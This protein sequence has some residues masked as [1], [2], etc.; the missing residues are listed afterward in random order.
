VSTVGHTP[1]SEISS[2][3]ATIRACLGKIVASPAFKAS[4][5]PKQFLTFVVEKT[6]EGCPQ[7]IKER[8][9]GTEVFGRTADFE[10]SGDSIVRVNANEVRRRLAQYYRD[11]P[12]DD[13]VQIRLPQGSYVPEFVFPSE[14]PLPS[15]ALVAPPKG[16]R[17]R[18]WVAGGVL[19]LVVAGAIVGWRS[20]PSGLARFW[21]PVLD[22]EVA[23][24]LCLPSTNTFQL[25]NDQSLQTSPPKTGQILDLDSAS[26]VAFHD[27]HTS[28]PVLQATVAVSGVLQR[29]GRTP[30]IRIGDDLKMDE[31]RG[32]PI[33][34]IGSFSNSWTQQNVAGLR[35]TFDRGASGTDRPSIRDAKNPQR[36]RSL[37]SIF[38]AAQGTDYAI[39]TRTFDPVTRE[40]FI[41]LAGLHSFGC[42]IAGE[43]VSQASLWEDLVRRA[44]RGW[45]KM[46]LQ[47]VLETKVIGTTT[48]TPKI[49]DFYFW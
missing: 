42:Q 36:I 45:Q 1:S 46:N 20:R 25:R 27:W 6:L 34:A 48:G 14:A 37:N 49:D 38:P 18:M 19:L 47:V 16:G 33:I 7:E 43:F 12:Q 29:M 8:T 31:I 41:S 39:V 32:H 17:R 10:T 40:P 35:F 4:T 5:R 30:L 2:R 11:L 22:Q 44:P 15:A 13:P 28:L 9:I 3:D 24:I 23:P 21:S 26:F